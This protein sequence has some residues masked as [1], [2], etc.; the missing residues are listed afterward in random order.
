ME[1]RERSDGY[2]GGGLPYYGGGGGYHPW[3]SYY[4]AAPPTGSY[5][6]YAHDLGYDKGPSSSSASSGHRE[7]PPQA[8]RSG[9][10]QPAYGP[11][12]YPPPARMIGGYY[13]SRYGYGLPPVMPPRGYGAG[14]ERYWYGYGAPPYS[15]PPPPL[16]PRPTYGRPYPRGAYG[17]SFGLIDPSTGHD[18]RRL[19][20][21][22]TP[23]DEKRVHDILAR[24]LRLKMDRKFDEADRLRD[25]LV[26]MGVMVHDREKTWE[27][28]RT[29]SAR[30]RAPQDIAKDDADNH[31]IKRRRDDDEPQP[32]RNERKVIDGNDMSHAP[33]PADSAHPRT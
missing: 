29:H 5:D 1:Q 22:G 25:E 13:D 27:V 7:P 9:P 4:G 14:H 28:R 20:D 31:G 32:P 15:P 16:P 17:P 8:T 3:A 19:E 11:E 2:P 30:H 26:E 6:N 24:R 10:E 18:Y 23:V 12:Y 33:P 21:G